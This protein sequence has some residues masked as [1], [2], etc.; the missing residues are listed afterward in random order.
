M[1]SHASKDGGPE[2]GNPYDILGVELGA[3]DAEITKAYR[4]LALKLHPDKQRQ[5]VTEGE[6]ADLA[7][8]FHDV[9]EARSFLLDPEHSE[10]RRKYDA[11]LRSTRARRVEDARRE[12][13]MT[14]RRKRMREELAANERDAAAGASKKR[15]RSGKGVVGAASADDD[16]EV[17]ETLRRKGKQMR[18]NYS[19]K[20][21]SDEA[22]HRARQ[23]MD[24]SERLERRQ[25]RVKWSRSKVGKSHSEHSL[26]ELLSSFGTVESVE[27]VGAKGNAALITFADESSCGPCVDAYMD[28]DVM[29][30]SLVGKRKEEERSRPVASSSQSASSSA[31][32]RDSQSR[33]AE[34]VEERKI[35][36]AAERERILRQ[37]EIEEEGGDGGDG[38]IGTNTVPSHYQ[39]QQQHKRN[40]LSKPSWSRA[41]EYPPQ[42]PITSEDKDLTPIQRLDRMEA[43]VLGN[44]LEPDA[45]ERIQC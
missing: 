28:S 42:F 31:A 19:A 44:L 35:R 32:Y 22:V 30:A 5:D 13:S 45:L 21:A 8:R 18:E 20:A 27:L 2:C 39:Q 33:D 40:E 9:K 43:S 14:E 38:D 23:K 3:A 4:K 7:K 41:E 24:A 17:V 15:Y 36:Q 12:Q 6:A 11:K 34:S 29:R 10:D 1:P 16:D 26:A 37:M 25:V